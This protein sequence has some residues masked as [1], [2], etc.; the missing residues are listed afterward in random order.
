MLFSFV[1]IELTLIDHGNYSSVLCG[2]CFEQLLDN[3]TSITA[4]PMTRMDDDR[5]NG[6]SSERNGRAGNRHQGGVGRK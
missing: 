4:L 6:A 5:L 3:E 2:G 1:T